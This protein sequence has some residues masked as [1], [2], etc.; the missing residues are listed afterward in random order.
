[1]NHN[2]IFSVV[3]GRKNFLVLASLTI[4][5]ASALWGTTT[6]AELLEFLKWILG[7]GVAGHAVEG[8]MEA[9]GKKVNGG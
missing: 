7:I 2:P 4:A 3:G 9:I 1:M 6:E 8:G 5:G